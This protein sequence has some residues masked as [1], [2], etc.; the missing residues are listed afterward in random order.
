MPNPINILMVIVGLALVVMLGINLYLMVQSRKKPP[1]KPD[2]KY[3]GLNQRFDALTQVMNDQ[4]ERGRQS[5]ER[6]TLTVHQQVQSFTQNMTQIQ[7]SMKQGHESVKG[8]SSFQEIFKSPK[9]RGIWGEQSLEASLQQYFSRDLY[10][11]QHYFRSGDAVDAVV[12]GG[13]NEWNGSREVEFR[14]VDL[15]KS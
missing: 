15:R 6:A 1:E 11:M 13:V 4:L 14:I 7:E 8:V 10:E 5:S 3:L 12:E 9:L 2:E